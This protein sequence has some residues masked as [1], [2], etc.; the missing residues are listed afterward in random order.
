MALDRTCRT[1]RW[2]LQSTDPA[3][4]NAYVGTQCFRNRLGEHRGHEVTIHAVGIE[5]AHQHRGRGADFGRRHL[6]GFGNPTVTTQPYHVLAHMGHG[7]AGAMR[8]AIGGVGTVFGVAHQLAYDRAHTDE[9]RVMYGD[10]V[11]QF[12]LGINRFLREGR[13]LLDARALVH[14]QVEEGVFRAELAEERDFV[15]ACFLRDPAGSRST[16]PVLGVHPGGGVE[17][18]LSVVVDHTSA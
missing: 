10:P 18:A 15:H 12:L 5:C 7:G 14:H 3:E 1:V 6:A 9:G 16:P 4:K 13:L 17:N 2:F 11:E 8:G